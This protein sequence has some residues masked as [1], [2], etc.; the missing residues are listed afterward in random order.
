MHHSYNQLDP[1][2]TAET[3]LPQ[4]L[5]DE[6]NNKAGGVPMAPKAMPDSSKGKL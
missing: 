2:P 3:L 1:S 5:K 4:F 6:I